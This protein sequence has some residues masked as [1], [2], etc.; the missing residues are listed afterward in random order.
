MLARDIEDDE[1]NTTRF[2]LLSR[3][4]VRAPSCNGPVTSF[5]VTCGT[6]RRPS[7]RVLG[8]FATNDVN[9]TELEL[10]W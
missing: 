8:G 5:I 10:T 4:F 7:T 9:V 6:C 3:E 1:D 2:A